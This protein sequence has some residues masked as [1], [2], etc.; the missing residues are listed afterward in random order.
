MLFLLSST[1]V[2]A[3]ETITSNKKTAATVTTNLLM[4]DIPEN[5][6]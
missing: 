4:R 5:I 1:R 2:T 3:K 6:L